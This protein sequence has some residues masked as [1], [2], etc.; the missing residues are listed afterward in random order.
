MSAAFAFC[1]YC[2]TRYAAAAAWPRQCAAC[3][4]LVWQNPLPVVVGL[5]PVDRGVLVIRRG[6]DPGRG[7]LALPGGFLESGET[8][9]AGLARE[10]RE[11]LSLTVDAGH[12]RLLTV[13]TSYRQDSPFAPA[14]GALLIFGVTP[15]VAAAALPPFRPNRE[16]AA[17]LVVDKPVPLLF[18]THEAALAAYFAGPAAAG[19]STASASGSASR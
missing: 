9:R 3:E 2:G 5:V 14:S 17:R 4:R 15:P 16:I 6:A 12:V 1:P 13:D 11:E 19:P 7:G 8:W 18:S 10:L